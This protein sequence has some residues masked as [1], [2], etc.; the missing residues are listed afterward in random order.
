[1]EV[2]SFSL[3]LCRRVDLVSHD[4]RDGLLDVLHPLHHL[5]LTHDVHILDERIVLLPER[6]LEAW[7]SR[8]WKTSKI[9]MLATTY[10]LLDN[11]MLKSRQNV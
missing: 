10:R 11:L 6:H 5:G 7:T 3:E 4:A 8:P 2:V 9:K 1:M